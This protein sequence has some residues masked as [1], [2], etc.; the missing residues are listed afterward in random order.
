MDY[1]VNEEQEL[2]KDVFLC[3]KFGRMYGFFIFC[4]AMNLNSTNEN[5]KKFC[6]AM[7]LKST[8]ENLKKFP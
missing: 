6:L 3:I 4:L 2:Q 7:N 5:L 1:L 8:N